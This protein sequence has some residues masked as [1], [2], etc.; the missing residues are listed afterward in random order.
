[1]MGTNG[2]DN[3]SGD[4]RVVVVVEDEPELLAMLE[5]LLALEGYETIG[6]P[7]PDV[8]SC[9]L[10]VALPALFLIDIMLPGVS[11]IELAQALQRTQYSSI[12]MI[13]MSASTLMRQLAADSGAFVATLNKPFELDDLLDLVRV[14]S[15]L[16]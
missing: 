10:G 7:R 9:A 5:D 14:H 3:Q 13:G 12:P 16:A 1:M 6:V 8:L 2:T 15:D 11:G 4:A